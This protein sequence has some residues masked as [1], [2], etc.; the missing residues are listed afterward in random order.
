MALFSDFVAIGYKI[1]L[2]YLRWFTLCTTLM[3]KELANLV[4]T[5]TMA[6][7]TLKS[8]LGF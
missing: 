4:P 7:I 8:A 6:I 1:G 5:N 3:R 2:N